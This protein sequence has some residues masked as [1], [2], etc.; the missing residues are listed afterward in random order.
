MGRGVTRRGGAAGPAV[1]R[2]ARLDAHPVTAGPLTAEAN[3]LVTARRTRGR[4]CSTWPPDTSHAPRTAPRLDAEVGSGSNA[5]SA[6]LV[7]M[8]EWEWQP[9]VTR[10][11]G[12]R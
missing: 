5:T 6:I 12:E 4:D 8:A 7:R 1:G 3:A 11:G 2:G 10:R 9:V